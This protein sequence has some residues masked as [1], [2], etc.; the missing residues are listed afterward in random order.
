M[1]SKFVT[2]V[3]ACCKNFLTN[4]FSIKSTI[5]SIS[6]KVL[7]THRTNASIKSINLELILI[8]IISYLAKVQFLELLL[9]LESILLCLVSLQLFSI[10]IFF[11]MLL[12]FFLNLL[13]FV[14]PLSFAVTMLAVFSL[15]LF[16]FVNLLYVRHLIKFVTLVLLHTFIVSNFILPFYVSRILDLFYV[17]R[18]ILNFKFYQFIKKIFRINN[19][20]NWTY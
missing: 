7:P 17:N 9:P 5:P 20:L 6:I 2:N 18:D 4:K 10:L 1:C 15:N 13:L 11:L 8:L 14:I 19:L 12:K 3:V 16:P